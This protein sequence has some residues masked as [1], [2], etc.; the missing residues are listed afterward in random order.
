MMIINKVLFRVPGVSTNN[1]NRCSVDKE[2]ILI[3]VGA[4]VTC[5]DA[6]CPVPT[7]RLHQYNTPDLE[8]VIVT[9]LISSHGS[10]HRGAP[11]VRKAE[12]GNVKR[13]T[14]CAGSSSED[15]S[16]F[17]IKWTEHVEYYKLQG[18]DLNIQLLECCDEALR[19]D[20]TSW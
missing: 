19:K 10:I 5:Q 12:H 11:S 15:W 18:R 3:Y 1:V 17:C 4:H 9:A 6:C 13:P 2:N 16:Y 14:I 20:L 8:A 7:L